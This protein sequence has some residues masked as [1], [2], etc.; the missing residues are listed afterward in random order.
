HSP[1]PVD[2]FV[3]ARSPGYEHPGT[4]H[5]PN[6]DG[7]VEVENI[8]PA[9]LLDDDSAIEWPDDAASFCDGPDDTQRQRTAL[10]S[11][12]IACNSHG[13]R[14]HCSTTDSLDE[15]RCNQPDQAGRRGID[16]DGVQKAQV[17]H[18]PEH[19]SQATEDRA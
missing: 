2:A 4:N 19:R 6:N 11:I 9:K 15:A 14:H 1:N 7:D 17:P 3:E 8:L 13:H 10:L 18:L 16:I 5:Q 12:E